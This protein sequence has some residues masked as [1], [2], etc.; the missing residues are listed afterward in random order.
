M[1]GNQPIE[2]LLQ[3]NETIVLRARE[4]VFLKVG[5]AAALSVLINDQPA[6]TLGTNRQVVTRLITRANYSSYLAGRS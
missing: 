4:E 1:D 6:K 5:D 2:R 3:P